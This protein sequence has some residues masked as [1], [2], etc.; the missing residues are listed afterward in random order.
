MIH[1]LSF[2][3]EMLFKEDISYFLMLRSILINGERDHILDIWK[4]RADNIGCD[5]N[6]R[7]EKNILEMHLKL[8]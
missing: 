5:G 4:K 2:Q 1:T 6:S 7:Y 8:V 3:F